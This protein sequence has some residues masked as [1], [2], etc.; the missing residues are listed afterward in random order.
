M[1]STDLNPL[2]Y[3]EYIIDSNNILDVIENEFLY[4]DNLSFDLGD[5]TD[6]KYLVKND[7]GEIIQ[8]SILTKDLLLPKLYREFQKAKNNLYSFSV[9]NT[10]STTE[11]YLTIQVKILQEIINKKSN[12]INSHIY[13]MLPLRGILNYINNVLLVPG[14]ERF[15]LD[16]SKISFNSIENSEQISFDLSHKSNIE[17]I[18]SVLDYMKGYNEKKEI[19]LN[20]EDFDQLINYT[21]DLIEKEEIPQIKN[22]LQPKVSNDLIRFSYWVL[23]KELYTTKRVRPYFYDFIKA[24]FLNF[25]ESDIKSIKSQF[26]TSTRAYKYD[27]IPDIISKHIK[28]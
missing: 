23:H 13:V 8:K 5:S 16:E 3:F 4:S 24:L 12:L 14:M 18:H 15:E 27:Y 25:K 2:A 19:I 20:N 7:F 21:K 22:Q 9:S 11:Y 1:N 10:K 26:G 28:E 6:I 17:I